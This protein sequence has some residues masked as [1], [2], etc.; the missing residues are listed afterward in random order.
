MQDEDWKSHPDAVVQEDGSILLKHKGK[1][2]T[3]AERET[4]IKHNTYMKFSRTFDSPLDFSSCYIFLFPY[5]LYIYMI[6]ATPMDS[7]YTQL[8]Q[9]LNII[10]YYGVFVLQLWGDNSLLTYAQVLLAHRQCLLQGLVESIVSLA[11]R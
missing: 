11:A 4:R 10:I 7:S 2:E 9:C 6:N 5:L 3:I 8:L 1:L